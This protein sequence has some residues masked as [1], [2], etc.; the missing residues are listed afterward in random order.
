MPIF[1]VGV[2]DG[3]ATT[4]TLGS[5]RSVASGQLVQAPP[6]RLASVFTEID[7]TVT[8]GYVARW[9]STARAGASVDVRAGLAGA[10]GAIHA[11]YAIPAPARHVPS[12]GPLSK[13]AFSFA[14]RLSALPS[15]AVAPV[16]RPITPSAPP[17]PAAGTSS[18]NSFWNS[19]PGVVALAGIVGV[20]LAVMIL[21]LFYRPSR[22]A[23]RTR[24]GSYIAGL[25]PGDDD[26]LT[27]RGAQRPRGSLIAR[28]EGGRYWPPFVLDV[29]ISLMP[30]TPV[31]LVKRAA[32]AGLI[33]GLL[34]T[35]ISGSALL[36]FVPI[37]GWPWALR[38]V[39]GRKARKMRDKFRDTLPTYLQDL[40]SA[41]RVG[42]SFPGALTAIAETADEPLK[43]AFER[44]I[45]DEALGRPLEE[46]LDAVATRMEA[47]DLAQ[48]ALI[49]GLNRR[50]GSN[51]SEALDRVAEGARE[52]ADL[53]REIKALTAQAKMSSIVLTALPGVL[54]IGINLVSPLYAHPLFHTTIGIVLLGVGSIM[55][56]MGWK[57]L[58]KI[59]NVED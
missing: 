18:P 9:R 36:G 30:Q 26:E 41:M 20:L 56:F 43:G 39:V 21:L 4:A 48:V 23:V 59:T 49:A 53:R 37:L 45:T 28:F 58:A 44:A 11:A 24:V 54:L 25:Q 13:S 7:A 8:R 27:L 14:H 32:A 29:E 15:F 31:A 46:A 38:K 52:R 57:A 47:P 10:A 12:A 19:Q 2:Q 33:L 40:A 22:R 16:A 42:R 5:L 17:A 34:V 6:A 55:V 1:T 50:S 3:A 51:V 35:L